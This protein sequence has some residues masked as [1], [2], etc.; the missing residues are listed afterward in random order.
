MNPQKILIVYASRYGQ[1]EKVVERIADVLR[2]E[3]QVAIRTAGELTGS[4]SP[5]PYHAVIVA[6]SVHFGKH[7]RSLRDFVRQRGIFLATVPAAFVSVSGAGGAPTEEGQ[8]E[9]R[10][11]VDRF[12]QETGWGPQKVAIFGGAV[13]YT[14]YNIFVRWFMKRLAVK[15]GRDFDTSRDYEYTDWAAVEQFARDFL[16]LL[17]GGRSSS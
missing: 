8:R 16:A 1:T 10:G 14:R 9:A 4:F 11:Y 2:N 12:L 5:A 15:R 6:G 7:Q 3:Q 13:P 17:E